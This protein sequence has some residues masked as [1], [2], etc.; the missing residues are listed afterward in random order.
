MAIDLK[1]PSEVAQDYLDELAVTKNVNVSQT[2]SDWWIRSQVIGGVVAGVYADQRLIANDAFPQRAREDAVLR[3]LDL[4]FAGGYIAATQS[5]GNVAVTGSLG[6]TIPQTTQFLYQPNG[7]AYQATET[8]VL[9]ATGFSGTQASGLVPVLS[10]A[11]GQNQNLLAGAPLT[12][13]S[14]PG[15]ILPSAVVAVNGLADAR[16]QETAAEARARIVARIRSPLSVGRVS[17][18]IQYAEAADPSVTSASVVR[19]PFGLGTVAVYIT[20]GTTNIDAAIDAGEPIS[21]IPSDALVAKVQAFLDVNRPV[22]DCV[23]VVKPVTQ[24]IDVTVLTKYSQGIGSTIISGQT[25]TQDQLVQREVSR[26]IYKTPVGGRQVAGSGFVF[27]SDI[28]QTI[29]VKLSNESV[30]VGSIPILSDRQ[31]LALSLTGY[32]YLLQANIVPIPGVIT[33]TPM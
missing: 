21:V 7:N 6:A 9:S 27:A 25:L 3:F 10:V 2:D 22:T 26:A 18:Y 19:Y 24:T 17:D 23:T 16:D 12:I 20:S 28:E 5:Q 11:A 4:Y 31:V 13:S 14:P 33:V 8:V 29:D 15:G 1:P 30:E 32:N